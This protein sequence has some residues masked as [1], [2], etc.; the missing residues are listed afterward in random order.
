MRHSGLAAPL[1]LLAA[2]LVPAPLAADPYLVGGWPQPGGSGSTVVITY[3]YSNLLDGTFLL[4]S[5]ADLRDATVEAF[6]VWAMAAPLQFVERPDSGPAPADAPYSPGGHPQIRIGH[7]GMLE[8]GHSFFPTVPDGRAGDIHLESGIPWTLG[9]NRWNLLEV[10]VHELGHALGLGHEE[11]EPAIMNPFF[12]QAR[13]AGLGTSFLLPPDLR[14]VRALYGSGRGSVI[15]LD[16]VPEPGSVLLVGA[17]LAML[18]T[19]L[20]GRRRT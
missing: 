8:L 11:D 19:G 14:A 10:L 7:H 9:E 15:P 6:S 4:L 18:A 13:F 12:P 1:A 3:S 16:P 5:E 17:G 20:R 2:A